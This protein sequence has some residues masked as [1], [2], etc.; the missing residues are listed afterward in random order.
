MVVNWKM[1][2][3]TIPLMLSIHA[4]GMPPKFTSSFLLRCCFSIFLLPLCDW[5]DGLI[6]VWMS[7]SFLGMFLFQ[8]P[9][10]HFLSIYFEKVQKESIFLRLISKPQKKKMQY[11]YILHLKHHRPFLSS[12]EDRISNLRYHIPSEKKTCEALFHSHRMLCSIC[13]LES[14]FLSNMMT[15]AMTTTGTARCGSSFATGGKQEMR[16]AFHSYFTF[17]ISSTSGPSCQ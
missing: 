12:Q 1:S 4:R 17:L 5:C 3:A 6:R 10:V 16:A 13:W 14:I 11:I 9:R 15:T 8:N 2:V 7:R